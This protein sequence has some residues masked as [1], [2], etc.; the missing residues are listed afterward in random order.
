MSNLQFCYNR[1]Q[2]EVMKT[3]PILDINSIDSNNSWSTPTG[4][5]AL[6]ITYT[7]EFNFF[8]EFSKHDFLYLLCLKGYCTFDFVYCTFLLV[9]GRLHSPGAGYTFQLVDVD[10]WIFLCRRPAAL[11]ITP[12]SVGS[13]KIKFLQIWSKMHLLVWL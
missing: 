10:W 6:F 12:L 11:F 8:F 9:P 1:F 3:N 2:L 13:E 4:H 7:D 5:A